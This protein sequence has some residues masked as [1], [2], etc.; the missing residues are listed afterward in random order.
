MASVSTDKSGTRRIRFVDPDGD[1]KALYLGKMPI[2][3]AQSVC[4]K[5]E[6]LLASKT[7]G[8]P[9]GRETAQWVASLDARLANKLAALGLVARRANATLEAFLDGYIAERVDV[10]GSTA[11]VYGHTKRNLIAFLGAGKVLRDISAGDADKFRLFLSTEGLASNTINRRCSI[12]KQFFRAAMRRKLIDE[13]LFQDLGASVKGN[14]EKFYFVSRADADKVL[15]ACPD[16]PWRLIF[17]LSRFGGLR[18][19]SE[20]LALTWGDVDWERGRMRVP[21]PKTAHHEGKAER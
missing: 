15:A 14:A 7:A 12:A 3:A 10:K 5:V 8:H 9:L 4:T 13:N 18:C 16:S 17:A 20:H 11:T 19:P 1:R 6:D 21:S 2:K